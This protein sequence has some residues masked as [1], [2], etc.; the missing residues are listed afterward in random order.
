MRD[1]QNPPPKENP[2]PVEGAAPP[3]KE[4]PDEGA[5]ALLA[6]PPKPKAGADEAAPPAGSRAGAAE[7]LRGLA[8]AGC[9]GTAASPQLH[10]CGCGVA[11]AETCTY[12]K[13]EVSEFG[14]TERQTEVGSSR[15]SPEHQTRTATEPS[16]LSTRLVLR[17]VC[18]R[19]MDPPVVLCCVVFGH[20][21]DGQITFVFQSV[22]APVPI[23]TVAGLPR[24]SFRLLS[25]R[26]R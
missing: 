15:S 14:V 11:K 6:A 2:P 12:G 9:K 26:D 20:K 13:Q 24:L 7:S 19:R 23:N 4:K 8:A 1:T 16:H 17:L 3:P 22:A 25:L 21:R 18:L 10:T 5:A